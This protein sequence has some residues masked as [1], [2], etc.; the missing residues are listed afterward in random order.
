M[1]LAVS[2]SWVAADFSIHKKITDSYV[3]INNQ[4]LR[5]CHKFEKERECTLAS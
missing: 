1:R 5:F 2:S 4:S 3:R